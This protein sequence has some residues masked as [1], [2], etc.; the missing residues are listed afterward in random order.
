M[1]R[2]LFYCFKF[3]INVVVYSGGGTELI[4]RIVKYMH[5]YAQKKWTLHAGAA[6]DLYQKASSQQVGGA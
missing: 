4:F 1:Q 5:T 3:V 6:I 2:I